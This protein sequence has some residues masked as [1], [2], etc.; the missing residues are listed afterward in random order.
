[1][2]SPSLM[3]V[4][5]FMKMYARSRQNWTEGIYLCKNS[6][7]KSVYEMPIVTLGLKSYLLMAVFW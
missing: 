1:M 2:I 6:C 7:L 5:L 3:L 4:S